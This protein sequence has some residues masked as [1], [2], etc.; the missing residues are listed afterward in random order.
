M[1]TIL[2]RMGKSNKT[3]MHTVPHVPRIG[4]HIDFWRGKR[5]TVVDVIYHHGTFNNTDTEHPE[6][7]TGV[8]VI[9]G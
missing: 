1:E 6:Q 3:A 8:E 5:F 7:Q 9:L 2:F 4:E